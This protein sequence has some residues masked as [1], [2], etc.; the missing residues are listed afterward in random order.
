[1]TAP[2]SR[3]ALFGAAAVLPLGFAAAPALARMEIPG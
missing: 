3:R 1:M 2:M